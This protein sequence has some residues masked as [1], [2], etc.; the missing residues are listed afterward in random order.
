M[1]LLLWAG[2]MPAT[3]AQTPRP[4]PTVPV[5]VTDTPEPVPAPAQPS[6]SSGTHGSIQG[7]VYKDV[8]GDGQCVGTGVAGEDPI[9]GV[10]VEFVSDD[11]QT[12]LTLYTGDDGRY[13]LAAAGFSYW[14]VTVKP[15]ADWVVTSEATLNALVSADHRAATDIN[16]CLQGAKTA[17]VLLPA[18][19]GQHPAHLLNWLLVVG[20]MLVAAGVI[21]IRRQRTA[22]PVKN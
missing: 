17:P 21:M 8:N 5:P 7:A 18:S 6:A 22:V 2:F 9:A 16:F 11:K 19:G 14:A 3:Q 13:G 4:T 20:L 15:S 1:S 12:V 10:D